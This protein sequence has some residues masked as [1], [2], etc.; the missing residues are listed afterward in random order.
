MADESS[1]TW[2]LYASFPAA[3]E[4]TNE[5]TR[6]QQ[7]S[8]RQ[9]SQQANRTNYGRGVNALTFYAVSPR[10]GHLQQAFHDFSALF[11]LHCIVKFFVHTV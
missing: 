6:P 7:Q 1:K 5:S 8:K 4:S 10:A 2:T 3:N 11:L 9:L